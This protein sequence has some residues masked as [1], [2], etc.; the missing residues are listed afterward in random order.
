MLLEGGISM[1]DFQCRQILGESYHRI[2][3]LLSDKMGL[4]DWSKIPEMVEIANEEDL[5]PSL[6]WLEEQWV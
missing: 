5:M 6:K 1:I 3:P 2:N 4:D